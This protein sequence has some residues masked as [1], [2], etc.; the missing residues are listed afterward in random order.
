MEP[1]ISDYSFTHLK[2]L[3]NYINLKIT[4]MY[5][6]AVDNDWHCE[7]RCD[8]INRLYF[9]LDGKAYLHYNNKTVTLTPGKVYLIPANLTYSYNCDNFMEH[10]FIHFS[11]SIIPQKD[12]LSGIQKIIDFN[13]PKSEFK[14]IKKMFYAENIKAAMFF[15]SYFY[16]LLFTVISPYDKQISRDIILYKQ[17][18]VLYDYITNNLYADTTV[19]DICKNTGYSQRH[20]S[21]KF[22]TDTGQTIK[23]YITELLVDKLKYMLSFTDI[24]IKEI[25]SQ[26]HFNDEFYCSRFFKKH[27]NISP[28]EYR[29]RNKVESSNI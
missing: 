12:L 21:Y 22:K 6:A 18:H 16:S 4:H 20:I 2:N 10:I 14:S 23:A 5:H 25:A 3:T 19:S 29:K 9:I 8:N 26:L 24:P 11:M 17:Y 28:R 13:V 1:Y 27:M 7:K 15:K